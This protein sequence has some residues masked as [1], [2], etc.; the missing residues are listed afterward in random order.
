MINFQFFSNY[1]ISDMEAIDIPFYNSLMYL[2]ENDPEPLN[3]T[4]TIL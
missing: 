3:L 2:L 4:F 1:T